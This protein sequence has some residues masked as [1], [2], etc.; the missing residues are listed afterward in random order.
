[1]PDQI[2]KSGI[3]LTLSIIFT[4]SIL[5]CLTFGAVP[6]RPLSPADALLTLQVEGAVAGAVGQALA[7]LSVNQ[8]GDT[9][10]FIIIVCNKSC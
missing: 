5:P 3:L 9:V 8:V 1:M 10:K 2:S 6:P 7:G 4:K